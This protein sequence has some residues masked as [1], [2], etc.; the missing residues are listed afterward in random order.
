MTERYIA[1]D[2]QTL[3]REIE[4]LMLENV[5]LAEDEALRADMVEGETD[6]HSVLSRIIDHR[7]EADAMVEAIKS[8]SEHLTERKARYER[9]SK[10]MTALAMRLMVAAKQTKIVLPEASLSISKGRESVEI[11]SLDDLPQGAFTT[12][13]QP[14]KAAIKTML[15]AGPVP[16]AEIK[17]GPDSLGVRVK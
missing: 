14:D 16:G 11:T 10:A 2:V 9:R 12:V 4:R 8:R 6:L 15:A 13:K 3:E 5:E 7:L 1:L 17:I